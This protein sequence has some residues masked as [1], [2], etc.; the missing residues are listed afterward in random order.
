MSHDFPAGM[1]WLVGAGPGD[2]ELLT[3][4]AERLIRAADVVFYDALVGEGVLALV[5]PGTRM[6]SVGKRSGRHSKAQGSINDLL[7]EAA[8][9]GQRVVRLKGGD[10]SVFGR[11]AEEI[12]HLAKGGVVAKVCPGI[13]TASAAAASAG[14][15]LTLRGSARG[16]T[17]VTAHLR[18][19][20]PL[21][22]DWATLASESQTVGVYMGRA[23]A[24]EIARGLIAAGRDPETPVMVAV[25]V[26]R[27]DERLIRGKLSTLAFL[28]ATISDDDPT[29]LLIGEA[30]RAPDFTPAAMEYFH[31]IAN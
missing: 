31:I 9:A 1:V 20:E 4:K 7:L 25:N 30:V 15:S 13:T 16:I 3:R 17:Y 28:V 22:L 26:S 21:K 18:A 11:S 6:V 29:L 5:R 10:P 2:P 24:G 27:P 19:G 23:A 14:A 12:E 8:L